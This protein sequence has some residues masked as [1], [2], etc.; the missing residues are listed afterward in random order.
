MGLAY[1]L[2]AA[3]CASPIFFGVLASIQPLDQVSRLIV[4]FSYGLGAGIPFIAVGATVPEIHRMIFWQYR[5]IAP[6]IKYFSSGILLFLAFYLIDTYYF[7]Y[8]PLE[9]S[10]MI[11][12]G[13]G[14][15]SWSGV[16]LP[17]F[18]LTVLM[19]AAITIGVYV[20]ILASNPRSGS[21]TQTE[22]PGT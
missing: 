19:I 21:I 16:L 2:I 9:L 20:W 7:P 11:Y 22:E 18:G 8:N 12:R 5:F 13:L 1:T 15:P 4:L 17:L 14:D 10:G 3:P 6:R